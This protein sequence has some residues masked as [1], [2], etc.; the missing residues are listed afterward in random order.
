[1]GAAAGGGSGGG[2]SSTA[3]LM[4]DLS[5]V[6]ARTTGPTLRLEATGPEAPGVETNESID[7][8]KLADTTSLEGPTEAASLANR[9]RVETNGK[10]VVMSSS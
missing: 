6:S 9:A 8:A 3:D 2:F 4:A 7:R 10:L 1:M 5:T